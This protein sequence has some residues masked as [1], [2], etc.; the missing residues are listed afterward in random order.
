MTE[1]LAIIR[2]IDNS[3]TINIAK[4]TTKE[5]GS[6]LIR[7]FSIFEFLTL[8]F[9][10]PTSIFYLQLFNI[11]I[12]GELPVRTHFDILQEAGFAKA[13]DL[14]VPIIFTK[15]KAIQVGSF[16]RTFTA[17]NEPFKITFKKVV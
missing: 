13:Y 12:N 5:S 15:S 14:V 9:Q 2:K 6:C 10:S 7:A 4:E 8:V 1:Y 16:A 11:F 3:V 17:S